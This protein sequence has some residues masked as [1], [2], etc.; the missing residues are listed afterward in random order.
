[1]RGWGAVGREHMLRC[2]LRQGIA[3]RALWAGLTRAARPGRALCGT[4][5]HAACTRRVLLHLY[6]LKMRG[7]GAYSCAVERIGYG[8]VAI[9]VRYTARA[10]CALQP[11]AAGRV[12]WRVGPGWREPVPVRLALRVGRSAQLVKRAHKREQAQPFGTSVTDCNVF[13]PLVR[14]C[15]SV[16]AD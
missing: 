15:R 14:R 1:M 6:R 13:L 9:A 7:G 8:I 11:C 5:A 3:S 2:A 12:E 16:L 4:A 10:C